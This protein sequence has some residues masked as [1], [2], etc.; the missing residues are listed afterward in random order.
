MILS[1]TECLNEVSNVIKRN[2][3]SK[4]MFITGKKSFYLSGAEIYFKSY[5]ENN[6]NI[7]FYDFDVN[8]KL[9]DAI[10]GAKLASSNCIDMI[11]C[12]GGGSVLDMGKLIKAFIN[13]I[14][15]AKNIANGNVPINNPDIPIIAI[16]TTAGS[17][18]E[19]TH[20]AVVYINDKKFS[21]A[22]SCLLPNYV[23]LDGNLTKGSSK[24][25]K[26]CN[27]LD[28][29]SQAIESS[30]ANNSTNQSRNFSYKA[31]EMCI[32]SFEEFVNEPF[33]KEIA[34][35][36]LE[37]AN[38]SGQAIN[39]SK[40]T[41]PHA[42]SYAIS[43]TYNIPHGHSVWFTLPAIFEI[44]DSFV[45]NKQKKTD[46]LIKLQET[47]YELKK[48]LGI[49]T[50]ENIQDF[51]KA[52]LKKIGLTADIIKD[53]KSNISQREMLAKSAN[54]ERLSNNPVS[55]TDSNIKEIFKLITN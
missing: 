42:W 15:N 52:F 26:A 30:W 43:S 37:A 34:Q 53:I 33:N 17:G 2:K 24:Y 41:A 40:T 35:S 9:E 54:L 51:F 13:D 31:L 44:H 19:S 39:I 36:M 10:R 23:F 16:P 20:F 50:N 1:Y 29:I 6:S 4:L 55:F 22:D 14:P 8:P 12:V 49:G 45:K 46:D 32:N 48:I 11:I 3:S 38:F 5:L 47:M 18:S 21:V 28:A 27:V 7:H 25:Q